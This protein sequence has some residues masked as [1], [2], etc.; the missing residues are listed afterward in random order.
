MGCGLSS[1][2]TLFG[3]QKTGSVPIEH[4]SELNMSTLSRRIRNLKM[5]WL[6]LIAGELGPV[7]RPETGPYLAALAES[8]CREAGMRPPAWRLPFT[9]VLELIMGAVWRG[10]T[11][12]RCTVR[13][14]VVDTMHTFHTRK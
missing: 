1:R 11:G 13:L 7:G 5:L 4:H 6:A 10:T 12:P 8:L 2:P 9:K 3:R 14:D